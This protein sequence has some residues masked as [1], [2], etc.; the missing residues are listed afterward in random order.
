MVPPQFQQIAPKNRN[1]RKQPVLALPPVQQPGNQAVARQVNR[2][3]N[4][5]PQN[6]VVDHPIL[7]QRP[8]LKEMWKCMGQPTSVL[9]PY[10]E[11]E[12]QEMSE[13]EERPN[14]QPKND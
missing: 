4:P 11:M 5:V 7:M 2:N 13:G 9:E 14:D 3:K 10:P 8:E 12:L 6:K 1:P